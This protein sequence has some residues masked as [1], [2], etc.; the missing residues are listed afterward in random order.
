MKCVKKCPL[1]QFLEEFEKH[2][3]KSSLM[4]RYSMKMSSGKNICLYEITR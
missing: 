4:G 2:G 3:V 1:F